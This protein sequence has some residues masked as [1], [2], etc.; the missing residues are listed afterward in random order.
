MRSARIAGPG[1]GGITG[2]AGFVRPQTPDT[3]VQLKDVNVEQRSTE[4]RSR[5]RPPGRV[6]TR[7]SSSTP[8]PDWSST[9]PSTYSSSKSRW[10]T[11][12]SRSRKFA[13]A[14]ASRA[15]PARGGDQ[16]QRLSLPHRGGTGGPRRADRPVGLGDPGRRHQ[17]CGPGED[18][19]PSRVV[20]PR[21]RG[22]ATSHC[23][24]AE[25]AEAGQN[26][27]TPPEA[28]ERSQAAGARDAGAPNAEAPSS[29]P[30][31][32]PARC[33]S[34]TPAATRAAAARRAAPIHRGPGGD[35]PRAAST[36][37]GADAAPA[38]PAPGIRNG[39]RADLPGF[40]GCRR[41]EPAADPRRGERP[42]HRGG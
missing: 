11:A 25:D 9:S 5:S 27:P 18:R 22:L 6:S 33:S 12:P 32:A 35:P 38:P 40:Q 24:I 17:A 13:P 23:P 36:V 31:A 7:R 21:P 10:M 41:D 39:S 16:P 29:M 28:H 20:A 30:T 34:R 8:P 42:E 2:G 14:S 26:C 4:P 37:P 3:A 1:R 19:R 15:G